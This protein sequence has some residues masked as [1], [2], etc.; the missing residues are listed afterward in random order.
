M[1]PYV[2]TI[3]LMQV[4]SGPSVSAKSLESLARTALAK[5]E[6]M[7]NQRLTAPLKMGVKTKPQITEFVRQRMK[8]EYGPL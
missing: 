4:L 1:L 3:A 2:L 5:V 8:D 7:R 6:K